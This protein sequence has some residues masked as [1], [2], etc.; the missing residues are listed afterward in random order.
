[1][2]P[3]KTRS[4]SVMAGTICRLP[5]RSTSQSLRYSLTTPSGDQLMA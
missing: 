4:F 1:M 2:P 5:E 3:M